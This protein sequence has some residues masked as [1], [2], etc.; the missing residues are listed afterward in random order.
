MRPRGAEEPAA[1]DRAVTHAERRSNIPRQHA[2][3][4][5]GSPAGRK[6]AIPES[7]RGAGSRLTSRSPAYR[8]SGSVLQGRAASTAGT[9]HRNH[10]IHDP[11]RRP[12]LPKAESRIQPHG[13]AS[14]GS[15]TAPHPKWTTPGTSTCPE[16]LLS[17]AIFS[18][19]EGA[20]ANCDL[21]P[22]VNK[23]T[24]PS[25]PT[26]GVN[27]DEDPVLAVLW[28]AE[29]LPASQLAAVQ[30][31]VTDPKDTEALSTVPPLSSSGAHTA[32]A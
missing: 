13:Q 9:T 29:D 31:V 14:T 8:R 17:L 19:S 7:R 2:A 28:E 23:S 10:Q 25:L 11:E 3:G 21:L 27:D 6:P 20:K 22:I 26:F 15:T 18:S 30:V 4:S 16:D 24:S 1:P 32:H 5:E 12:P